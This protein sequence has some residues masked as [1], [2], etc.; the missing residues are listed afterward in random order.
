[1]CPRKIEAAVADTDDMGMDDK[2]MDPP[3]PEE[4]TQDLGLPWEPAT[5]DNRVDPEQGALFEHAPAV[6]EAPT[7]ASGAP[8][9]RGRSVLALVV[10][11]LVLLSA[12]IGIGWTLTNRTG[13]TSPQSIRTSPKP[14]PQHTASSSANLD[15]RAIANRGCLSDVAITTPPDD[16]S[17]RGSRPA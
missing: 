8:P 15:T 10:A 7:F 2:G 16:S 6:P 13:P 11:A 9:R 14:V 5:P 4:P 12:G 17:A 3:G 1:M